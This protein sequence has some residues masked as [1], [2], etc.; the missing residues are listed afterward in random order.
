MSR[1][2]KN[3]PGCCDCEG[4]PCGPGQVIC[5]N[6]SPRRS[7]E[8]FD[9]T[10]SGIPDVIERD[11]LI[12]SSTRENS[13]MSGLSQANGTYRAFFDF[14]ECRWVN[15]VF[16]YP[17]TQR[18]RQFGYPPGVNVC[19]PTTPT[20]DNSYDFS[21]RV[22]LFGGLGGSVGQTGVVC[23]GFPGFNFPFT[24]SPCDPDEFTE[25]VTVNYDQCVGGSIVSV[26]YTA[27]LTAKGSY[28]LL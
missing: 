22:S 24:Q 27:T 13:V 5:N 16:T 9:I 11:R 19:S 7:P 23:P 15:E 21:L 17:I 25:T 20:F 1:F 28:V 2:K 6:F 8:Y 18:C 10:I 12:F 3:N 4:E 26:S 14:D